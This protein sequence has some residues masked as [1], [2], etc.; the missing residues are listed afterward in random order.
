M[1]TEIV[2]IHSLHLDLP[3]CHSPEVT[4]TT[5][6]VREKMNSAEEVIYN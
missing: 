4:I 1:E 6:M 2:K 3:T 5:V